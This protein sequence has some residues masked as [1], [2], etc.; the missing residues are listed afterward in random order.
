M[1]FAAYLWKR[2]LRGF[3]TIRVM[4]EDVFERGAM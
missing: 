1:D 2:G 3:S 4:K